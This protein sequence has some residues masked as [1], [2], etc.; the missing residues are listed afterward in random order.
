[1]INHGISKKK[2]IQIPIGVDTNFFKPPTKLQRKR[3]RN[4][5]NFKNDEIIIGSFQKDGQGWKDGMV[6]KLIKGTR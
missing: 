4:L 6:P 1:M 2:I 5:F 3:A